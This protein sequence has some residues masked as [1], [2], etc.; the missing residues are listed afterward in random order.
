MKDPL[1]VD[2]RA[3]ESRNFFFC[4]LEVACA[5][6]VAYGAERLGAPR[7]LGRSAEYPHT[8]THTYE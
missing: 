8:A 3:Q 2:E 1:Q 6:H 5:G 7:M 4:A